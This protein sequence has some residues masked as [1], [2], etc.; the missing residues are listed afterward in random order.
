MPM[1]RLGLRPRSSQTVL[2]E[3]EADEEP[4]DA[5]IDAERYLEVVFISNGTGGDF[6]SDTENNNPSGT[7]DDTKNNNPGGTEEGGGRMRRFSCRTA[8]SVG[9]FAAR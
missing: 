8:S 2:Y 1:N 6:G 9:V 5:P 7:G 3:L 4:Y